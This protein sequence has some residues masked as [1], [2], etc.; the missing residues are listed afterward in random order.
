MNWPGGWACSMAE[1]IRLTMADNISRR[2]ARST[3][4]VYGVSALCFALFVTLMTALQPSFPMY[5]ASS[6]FFMLGFLVCIMRN[7]LGILTMRAQKKLAAREFIFTPE[8]LTIIRLS[9]HG[10]DFKRPEAEL[11]CLAGPGGRDYY[12][13]VKAE[14]GVTG[15]CYAGNDPAEIDR[16][17]E[18]LEQSG[19]LVKYGK[20]QPPNEADLA[21]P[22]K[23][24]FFS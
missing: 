19:A 12:L 14:D 3:L 5:A 15:S 10:M 20:P 17:A 21:G 24:R 22:Y 11:V 16:L 9:G 1:F 7:P 13:I 4:A 23:D 6:L 18:L 2:Y 8:G